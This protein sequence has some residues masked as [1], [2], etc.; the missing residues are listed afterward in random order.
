MARNRWA[1]AILLKIFDRFPPESSIF[2]DPGLR[3]GTEYADEVARPF[4]RWFSLPA[5]EFAR[6]K[7][8]LDIGFGFGGRTVRF[9]ELGARSV[10]GVEVDTTHA[11]TALQFANSKSV[12]FDAR[13]GIGE[14]LPFPA[15]SF[16]LVTMYDVME[17]VLRPREVLAECFR[18][19]RPGGQLAVVFPPYYHLTAGAH[20][21]GY[22]TSF[23]ALNLLFSTRA[24]RSATAQHLD[25]GDR[26]WREFL[27]DAKTDKLWNLNG[28][29]VCGFRRLLTE[30]PF[31]VRMLRYVG[32]VDHRL[33]RMPRAKKRLFLPAFLFFEALAAMPVVR[34]AFCI[35][36]A[37]I[38]AK[39]TA[40][41]NS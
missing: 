20:L 40:G 16:D 31:E 17:H 9:A 4:A 6:G 24:L 12:T 26:E 27:R 30:S 37:A 33:S 11:E 23:P 2:M 25:R 18:V 7:D 28:L 5:G 3:P 8:I 32:N 36:I 14:S 13:I 29:T 21:S 22:A 38:L 35:R 19:L 41:S 1:E 39:P 15:D 10:A 34:E